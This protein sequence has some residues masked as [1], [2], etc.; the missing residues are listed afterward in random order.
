M[1]RAPHLRREVLLCTQGATQCCCTWPKREPGTQ[2][3]RTVRSRARL[4]SW[5]RMVRTGS[6][7]GVF[8][9]LMNPDLRSHLKP[10]QIVTVRL[11]PVITVNAR[12]PGDVA[13][14]RERKTFVKLELA[15]ATSAHSFCLRLSLSWRKT[16]GFFRVLFQ[17][18]PTLFGVSDAYPLCCFW[19][20]TLTYSH[21]RL[22]CLAQGPSSHLY[23]HSTHGTVI[24]QDSQSTQATRDN[25]SSNPPYWHIGLSGIDPG[26]RVPVPF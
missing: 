20:H 3:D 10:F 5:P 1:S 24:K 14:S 6:Q 2:K 16:L 13:M 12:L 17:C 7:D 21:T 26:T 25:P 8:H 19:L 18:P 22:T 15:E 4:S 11:L 9:N 23:S